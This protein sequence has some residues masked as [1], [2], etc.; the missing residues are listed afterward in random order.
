M[1]MSKLGS[2][3]SDKISPFSTFINKAPPPVALKVLKLC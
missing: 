1:F 2:E 3:T